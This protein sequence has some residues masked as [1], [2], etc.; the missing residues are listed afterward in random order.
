MTSDLSRIFALEVDGRPT[1]AFKATRT[2]EAQ[3][4]C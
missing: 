3:A 2:K 4:I 1:L